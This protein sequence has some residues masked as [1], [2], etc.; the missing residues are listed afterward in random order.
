MAPDGCTQYFFGSGT[1]TV[2]T[3]NFDGGHHLANQDQSICVRREANI[4]RICWTTV[5]HITDFQLSGDATGTNG[6]VIKT[7]GC[8]GY[9]MDGINSNGYDCVMIPSATKNTPSIAGTPDDLLLAH[10]ICGGMF[11]TTSNTADTVCCE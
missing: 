11:G 9:G 10:G 5:T 2:K 3:F 7:S 1:D 6:M 4:C 8:C